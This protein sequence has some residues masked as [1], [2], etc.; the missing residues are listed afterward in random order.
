M[1]SR[2]EGVNCDYL[3]STNMLHFRVAIHS[4]VSAIGACVP[5]VGALVAILVGFACTFGGS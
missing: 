2:I 1:P 5:P 4:V 3:V